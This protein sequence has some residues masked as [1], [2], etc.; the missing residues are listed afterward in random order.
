M[1]RRRYSPVPKTDMSAP[2]EYP[3][4]YDSPMSGSAE[5]E[6]LMAKKTPVV[7]VGEVQGSK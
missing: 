3:G 5:G 4:P 1:R 6:G 2:M 7:V